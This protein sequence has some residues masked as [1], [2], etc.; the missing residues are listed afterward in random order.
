MHCTHTTAWI[1]TNDYS[2]MHTMCKRSSI[3]R[4][5]MQIK[6]ATWRKPLWLVGLAVLW[7]GLTNSICC[8]M[9]LLNKIQLLAVCTCYYYFANGVSISKESWI[10]LCVHIISENVLRN[11]KKL[12][13]FLSSLGPITNI[14]YY[15]SNDN[16]N[17]YSNDNGNKKK[18]SE[19]DNF[20]IERRVTWSVICRSF[21]QNIKLCNNFPKDIFKICH[22]KYFMIA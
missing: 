19:L 11:G 3:A 17:K 18:I 14:R 8:S 15:Y 1:G 13:F 12:F 2:K 6:S 16:S 4:Y 21:Q 7:N 20:S 5:A 10:H 22:N 9:H